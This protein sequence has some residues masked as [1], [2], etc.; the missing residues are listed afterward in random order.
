V[1]NEVL[2]SILFQE[3]I[4]LLWAAAMS[5]MVV[6]IYQKYE[7]IWKIFFFWLIVA[8]VLV[9]LRVIRARKTRQI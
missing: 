8:Q 9:V 1:S 3:F 4:A 5:A 6:L 2:K 7:L